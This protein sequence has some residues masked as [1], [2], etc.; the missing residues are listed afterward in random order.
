ME[1]IKDSGIVYIGNKPIKVYIDFILN[2]L[3][4]EKV[5]ELKVV[6]GGNSIPYAITVVEMV[7]ERYS[8][9]EHSINLEVSIR[10]DKFEEEYKGKKL[11]L[12]KPA[13][14]IT[15]KDER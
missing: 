7:K 3:L 14:E 6:A 4:A 13:I 10:V 1:K 8:D 11:E 2:K 5:K 15:L 12:T 9:K